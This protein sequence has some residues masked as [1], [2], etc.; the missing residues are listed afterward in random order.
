MV[1]LDQPVYRSPMPDRPHEPRP[2]QD[3]PLM[4]SIG[5]FF[6]HIVHG[7]KADVDPARKVTTKTTVE[8]EPRK[9]QDGT[10]ILR[11]TIIEEV[12]VPKK[13]PPTP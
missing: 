2:P 13:T 11:R 3:K 10:V 8:E 6:G 4:R 12:E 7:V 1:Q 5:E 9:T